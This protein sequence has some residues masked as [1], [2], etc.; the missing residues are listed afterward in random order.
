MQTT[1]S[2]SGMFKSLAFQMTSMV[3]EEAVR[4]SDVVQGR[5]PRRPQIGGEQQARAALHGPALVVAPAAV[6][7][8]EPG[9]AVGCHPADHARDMIKVKTGQ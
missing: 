8:G 2:G 6:G 3:A 5:F 1:C 4:R 9:V 7:A